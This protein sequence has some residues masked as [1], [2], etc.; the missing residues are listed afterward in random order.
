M[1]I[2]LFGGGILPGVL[3]FFG[4]LFRYRSA[5]PELLAA[6]ALFAVLLMAGL[7][8]LRETTTAPAG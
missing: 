5:D 6:G 4:H 7:F 2:L 8:S 1:L 3:L